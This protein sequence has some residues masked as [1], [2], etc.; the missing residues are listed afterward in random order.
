MAVDLSSCW[1]RTEM[2]ERSA[3][4]QKEG[5]FWASKEGQSNGKA[6]VE[7]KHKASEEQAGS[8]S[9]ALR[10]CEPRGFF[11]RSADLQTQR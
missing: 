4:R 2:K 3:T 5:S 8:G 11:L 7:Q 1:R 6:G 9:G 10:F